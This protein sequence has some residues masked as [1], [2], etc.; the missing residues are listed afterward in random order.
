M[1]GN[2]VSARDVLSFFQNRGQTT[3]TSFLGRK[4]LGPGRLVC[5]IVRKS[6]HVGF[7]VA[8]ESSQLTKGAVALGTR[9]GFQPRVGAKVDVEVP[10]VAESFPAVRTCVRLLLGV[11]PAVAP[12]GGVVGEGPVAELAGVGLLPSVDSPV[13]AE[14]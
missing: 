11:D 1:S 7:L 13:H 2:L 5:G 4:G 6:L 8:F 10:L 12:K 14:V 3:L 9:V